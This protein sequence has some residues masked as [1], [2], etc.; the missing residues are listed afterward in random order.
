VSVNQNKHAINRRDFL[1]KSAFATAAITAG[2]N[3]NPLYARKSRASRGKKVIVIGIDGMDPRLSERMMDAEL[4]PNFRKLREA[5]GYSRLG[6]S[7][8]PQSP[9][10]WANFITGAGSGRHGIYDF[11]H[12]EADNNYKLINAISY[13]KPGKGAIG[14]GDH[15]LQLDFCPLTTF[16]QRPFWLVEVS[17][18]GS[19]S[20]KRASLLMYI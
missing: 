9:V 11:V 6:T 13:T 1:K 2:L 5:G 10:A 3:V 7:T 15:L 8:P 14:M 16:R 19:I 17:L 4:L 18:S 12:R 20:M